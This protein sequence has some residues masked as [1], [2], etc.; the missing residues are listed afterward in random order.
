M[1]TRESLLLAIFVDSFSQRCTRLH[2]NYW[3]AR[4]HTIITTREKFGGY[5]PIYEKFGLPHTSV[6]ER[7][8]QVVIASN[9]TLRMYNFSSIKFMC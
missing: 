2:S 4:G 5:F 8:P 9:C 6:R 7:Y 3:G 1:Y